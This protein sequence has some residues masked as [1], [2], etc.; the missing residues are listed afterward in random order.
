[1]YNNF[2]YKDYMDEYLGGDLIGLEYLEKTII[3]YIKDNYKRDT[4]DYTK[5]DYI[6]DLFYAVMHLNSCND[7]YETSSKRVADNFDYDLYFNAKGL[8]LDELSEYTGYKL[9]I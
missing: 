7:I 8:L 9:N 4:Y 3:Q 1:M 5:E 2:V 6:L